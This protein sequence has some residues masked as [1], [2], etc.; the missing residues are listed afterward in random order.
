M[1]SRGGN[2]INN[3]F[4]KYGLI[5]FSDVLNWLFDIILEFIFEIM[6]EVKVKREVF[7]IIIFKRNVLD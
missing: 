7:F 1:G 3:N 4:W 6:V 2:A 5:W